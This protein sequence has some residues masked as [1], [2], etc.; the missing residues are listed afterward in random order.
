MRGGAN[1]KAHLIIEHDGKGG[2]RFGFPRDTRVYSRKAIAA[3]LEAL[4]QKGG[5]ETFAVANNSV[6]VA[7]QWCDHPPSCW[8]HSKR[9]SK[10]EC[11]D[12][13]VVVSGDRSSTTQTP[14]LTLTG[15]DDDT[16]TAK[17][18]GSGSGGKGKNKRKAAGFN[19]QS[20]DSGN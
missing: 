7:A 15:T 20:A 17:G 18:K 16:P 9:L 4:G 5:C 14:T 6:S 12:A 13:N 1:S 3:A 2:D 11:D 19:R 8:R 10:N